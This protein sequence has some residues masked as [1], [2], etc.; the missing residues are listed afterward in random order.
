ME[1]GILGRGDTGAEAWGT[2]R[3]GCR[4]SHAVF[5][6]RIWTFEIKEPDPQH[7]M[8]CLF[9][10]REAMG[11]TGSALVTRST[12]EQEE[13]EARR[14]SEVAQARF[15]LGVSAKHKAKRNSGG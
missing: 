3:F 13:L 14:V 15:P 5:K 9:P 4:M 8:R 10:C 6:L 11:G 7:N 12:R 2:G 1:K